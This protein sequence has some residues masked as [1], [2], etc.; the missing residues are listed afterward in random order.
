MVVDQDQKLLLFSHGGEIA[1]N[2]MMMI[3][4][5]VLMLY[6]NLVVSNFR[7]STKANS[8]SVGFSEVGLGM[9][10]VNLKRFVRLY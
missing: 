4:T 9:K 10:G 6:S 7:R 8:F 2:D 3:T 1:Q 5:L